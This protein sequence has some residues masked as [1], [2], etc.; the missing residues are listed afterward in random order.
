M[1]GFCLVRSAARRWSRRTWPKCC[2]AV[3]G[4]SEISH[5]WVSCCHESVEGLRWFSFL[6]RTFPRNK[7]H[8]PSAGLL[9]HCPK[10]Y[11]Q[12]LASCRSI[13]TLLVFESRP[14]KNPHCLEIN[15]ARSRERERERERESPHKNKTTTTKLKPPP[16]P[17]PHTHTQTFVLTLYRK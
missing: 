9:G 14:P 4:V 3:W 13:E 1:S 16:P 5:V 6:L 17:P 15:L 7:L 10:L 8:F 11:T 2:V 12:Q